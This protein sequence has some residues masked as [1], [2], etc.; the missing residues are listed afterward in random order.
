MSDRGGD[1]EVVRL[2]QPDQPVS[3]QEEIF[4][5]DNAHGTSM[6][7]MVGP[8]ARAAHRE[9][10]VECSQPPLHPAQPG[11]AAGSAPPMPEVGDRDPQQAVRMPTL[12][13]PSRAPECLAAL[14]ST[15][16]TAK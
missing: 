2:E 10:A 3:Q 9:Y 14:V 6:T 8:P 1:L 11:A 13:L 4:G 12:I 15:S 7:T 5:D 16:A